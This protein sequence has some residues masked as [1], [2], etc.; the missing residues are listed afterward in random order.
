MSRMDIVKNQN[1]H[2]LNYFS[3]IAKIKTTTC[4]L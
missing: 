2:K 4:I 1:G 3:S